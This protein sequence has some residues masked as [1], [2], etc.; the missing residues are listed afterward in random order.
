M[1]KKILLFSFAT[2]IM[3]SCEK[4]AISKYSDNIVGKW[5]LTTVVPEVDVSQ[6]DYD[7]SIEFT[8]DHEIVDYDLCENVVSYGLWTIQDNILTLTNNELPIPILLKILSLTETSMSLEFDDEI[9]NFDR[10]TRP[11]PV[12][13]EPDT[14]VCGVCELITND[15]GTISYGTPVPYCGEQLFD[16]EESSPV[17]IG[18][19]TTY[20]NCTRNSN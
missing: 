10:D 19:I 3:V 20:W 16:K 17:T 15:N 11:D 1:I 14:T 2:I 7:G 12:I 6:C 5:R 13:S 9:S 4:D 18:G 8:S